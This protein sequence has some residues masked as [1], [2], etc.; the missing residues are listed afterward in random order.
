MTSADEERY[1][2]FLEKIREREHDSKSILSR[3]YLRKMEIRDRQDT[4]KRW[5]NNYS[6]EGLRMHQHADSLEGL[7]NSVEFEIS[8]EILNCHREVRELE[9]RLLELKIRM[10]KV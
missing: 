6:F 1:L 4:I 2:F 3:L 5:A 7:V 8:K 9:S 10:G